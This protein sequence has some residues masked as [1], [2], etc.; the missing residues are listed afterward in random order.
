MGKG[1]TDMCAFWKDGVFPIEMK[2]RRD[3]QTYREGLEQWWKY[4]GRLGQTHGYLVLFETTSSAVIPWEER[5]KW[6]E[7]EHGGERMTVVE[8]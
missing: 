7:V 4:L 2:I 1:C 3:D 8:L 5:L 6:Y